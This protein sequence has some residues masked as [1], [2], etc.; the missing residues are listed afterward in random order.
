[1]QAELK[2][3]DISVKESELTKYQKVTI[4][5]VVQK[6]RLN[7][8]GKY[9]CVHQLFI[10]GDE[11]TYEDDEG[12]AIT[13]PHILDKEELFPFEMQQPSGVPTPKQKLILALTLMSDKQKKQYKKRV[14]LLKRG[15]VI[16]G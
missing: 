10:A 16:R 7:K 6:Y 8:K 13:V 11:V 9:K 14:K 12:N 3:E 4:G 15:I 5:F 1:M 2:M